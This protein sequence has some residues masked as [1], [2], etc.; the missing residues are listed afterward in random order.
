M[1]S[2]MRAGEQYI[3]DIYESLRNSP[4]WN[5]TLFVITYDEHGGFYDHVSP[6][7]KDIP[8]P[9]DGE[10]SYPTTYFK[11]DRLG[12]RIPTLLISPWI[13]KGT[14]ISEPPDKAKPTS[15]SEFDL[16]SIIASSRKLLRM[17]NVGSLTD[18]GYQ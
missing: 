10:S 3:K 5:D 17:D 12:V 8:P 2:D 16:T 15:S 4:Q 13:Q 11:F 1:C 6:P 14:V 9:G 18:R 7:Q